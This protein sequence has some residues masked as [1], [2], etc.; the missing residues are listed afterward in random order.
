MDPD[1]LKNMSEEEVR[2][3]QEE[4]ARTLDMTLSKYMEAAEHGRLPGFAELKGG[5]IVVLPFRNLR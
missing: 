1:N 3:W 5:N 2:R 4:N